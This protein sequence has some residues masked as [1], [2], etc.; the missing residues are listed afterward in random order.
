M[1]PTRTYVFVLLLLWL[2][3]GCNDKKQLIDDSRVKLIQEKRQL[4]Q[5]KAA[6]E[7][8]IIQLKEQVTTLQKFPTDRM[9]QLVRVE[10]IEFGKFTRAYD[11]DI[12][13]D[14][15]GYDDGVLVYLVLKDKDGDVI[16]AAG[17][18]EIELWDRQADHKIIDFQVPAAELQQ[19]WLSG[20]L[21]NHYKFQL[22]WPKENPPTHKILILTLK[23][24]ELL[25]GKNIPADPINIEAR[26][27]PENP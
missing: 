3:V 16:K 5:D 6:L 22:P 26:I 27:R 24:K 25:T 14:P 2:I 13:Q 20:P 10:K 19:Y 15:D 1:S 11:G 12:E 4:Q 18:V 21:T 17:T 7:Q 8:E 23:F 9:A